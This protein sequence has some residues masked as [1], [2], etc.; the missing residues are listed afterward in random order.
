MSEIEKLCLR[1]EQLA[2][3]ASLLSLHFRGEEE[4][5]LAVEA[6]G[7]AKKAI[8]ELEEA[9]A[10]QEKEDLRIWD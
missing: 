7:I 3:A 6:L 2:T 8:R 10:L 9:R 1:A 5:Q 4:R